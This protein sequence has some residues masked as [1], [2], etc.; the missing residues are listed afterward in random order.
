M[1]ETSGDL[2]LIFPENFNGFRAV[3]VAAVIAF[4]EFV[5]LADGDSFKSFSVPIS[6]LN[7]NEP[8]SPIP[9]TYTIKYRI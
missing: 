7:L 8:T 5:K 3:E 4:K 9:F 1:T 2:R 6:E